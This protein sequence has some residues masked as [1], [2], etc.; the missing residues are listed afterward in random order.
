MG[1]MVTA[2]GTHTTHGSDCAHRSPVGVSLTLPNDVSIVNFFRI[3]LFFVLITRLI[4]VCLIIAEIIAIIII[5]A[6][7]N[8]LILTDVLKLCRANA[9]GRWW[10]WGEPQSG[11]WL[12]YGK[13]SI[14][15]SVALIV[16]RCIVPLPPS[17]VV[18]E[19]ISTIVSR[20]IRRWR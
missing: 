8:I 3:C 20:G 9:A 11:G 2:A 5:F 13:L 1:T 18:E 15:R 6:S 4:R 14:M 19:N 7:L 12:C 17:G 16:N 10:A